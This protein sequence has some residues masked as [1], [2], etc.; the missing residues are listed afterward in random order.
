MP[1]YISSVIVC[2]F[3]ISSPSTDVVWAQDKREE[4]DKE[5]VTRM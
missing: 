4:H 1:V 2:V 3:F 5:I